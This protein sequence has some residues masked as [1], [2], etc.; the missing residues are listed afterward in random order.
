MQPALYRWNEAKRRRNIE[1]H[2][3]DF[4]SVGDFDWERAV[5]IEDRRRDYGETR[6]RAFGVIGG[7]LHCLVFTPRGGQVHVISLRKANARESAR[8]AESKGKNETAGR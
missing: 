7:R 5:V 3:V 1:K 2:G 6:L 4:A 8:Y